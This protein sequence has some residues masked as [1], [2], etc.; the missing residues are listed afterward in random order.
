MWEK[1]S[2]QHKVLLEAQELHQQGF[3]SLSATDQ[4]VVRTDAQ[5]RYIAYAL[6]RQSG[7]Q[8][9]HLKMDLQN[10]YTTGDNRCPKNRQQTLHLLDKYSKTTGPHTTLSEGASFA[11]KTRRRKTSK[12]NSGK[13]KTYDKEY[14][15]DKKC[16]KCDEKGHPSIHCPNAEDDDEKSRSSQAK[17]VKKL[18][19]EVKLMKKAFAQL[20]EAKEESDIS[21]SEQSE[22]D[23]ERESHFLHHDSPSFQFGQ[24]ETELE[25]QIAELFQQ[26][27]VPTIQLDLRQVI[28]LDSQSTIDLICNKALVTDVFKSNTRM[29]LKSNGGTMTVRQQAKIKGY[30]NQRIREEGVV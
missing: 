11:Q 24:V 26:K 23:E 17:S 15:K 10:D 8:H 14:W 2:G 6:L 21:D 30:K 13:A 29:R 28:L 16:F 4:Q 25:P 9:D 7:A 19:R 1:Q 18:E 3:T 5:E 27:H 20:K 22:G 12:F